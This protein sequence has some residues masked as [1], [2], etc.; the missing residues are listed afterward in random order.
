LAWQKSILAP[1]DSTS[2]TKTARV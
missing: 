2:S 1:Q